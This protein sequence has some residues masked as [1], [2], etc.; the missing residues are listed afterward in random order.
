MNGVQL[1]F[2]IVA[3]QAYLCY[4]ENLAEHDGWVT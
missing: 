2:L 1:R 4:K 3:S